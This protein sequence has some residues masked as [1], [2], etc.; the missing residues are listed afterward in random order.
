MGGY[1]VSVWKAIRL[2]DSWVKGWG[3][4]YVIGGG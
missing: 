4:S 3:L 1:G 2:G